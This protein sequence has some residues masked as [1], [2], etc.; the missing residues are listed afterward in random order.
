MD[1]QNPIIAVVIGGVSFAVIWV[2]IWALLVPLVLPNQTWSGYDGKTVLTIVFLV[3][4]VV[5]VWQCIKS[6]R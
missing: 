3:G 1:S 2:M 6:R 4:C 5:G